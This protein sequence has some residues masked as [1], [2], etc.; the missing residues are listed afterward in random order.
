MQGTLI[1]VG[2]IIIGS[3]IGLLIH[4]RLPKNIISITFQA[5]GLFTLF[6]G[7]S[8]ALKTNNFILMIFS[9]VIGSIIGEIIDIEKHLN[10]FS[11][12]LKRKSKSKN[13]K[14]SEG[15]ITATLLFC[16]GSMAILGAIE[17]GLG[18]RPNILLAKS[19]LDGFSSLALASSLG[20]GVLFS[21]IPL[22]LYQGGITIFASY[23]QAFFTESIIIE[24]TAIGGILLI[25]LGISLLEIKKIKVINMLPSFFV[26]IILTYI[27]L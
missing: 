12:F 26:V 9:I 14:F 18:G 2:A 23:L 17:E 5:I 19:I 25:G 4:S 11:T 21:I 10:N 1:N 20:I 3:I 6:L 27:F 22:F 15:F 7:I 24:S 16:V 8:M 13:E